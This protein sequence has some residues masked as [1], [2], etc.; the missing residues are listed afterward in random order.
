[1]LKYSRQ[2]EAILQFLSTRTDHPTADC[3]YTNLHETYP[4][5]SLGTVYRNL[6]LLVSTGEIARIVC[7][8]ADHFDYD[9]SPHHH[10]ECRICH[11]VYDVPVAVLPKIDEKTEQEVGKVEGCQLIF[12]GICKNCQK[13]TAIHE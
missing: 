2:R 4:R 5:L 7:E 1:M 11:Q 12:Y 10:F 6:N 8:E 13:M 3:V 9:V